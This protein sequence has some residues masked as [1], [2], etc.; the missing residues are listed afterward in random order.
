MTT[1]ITIKNY[2]FEIQEKTMREWLEKFGSCSFI[3]IIESNQFK[4]GVVSYSHTRD[5]KKLLKFN[6][7]KISLNSIEFVLQLEPQT[8]FIS[9]RIPVKQIR[10]NK[11][12]RK[13]AYLQ[14]EEDRDEI[15]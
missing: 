2:P 9:R 5:A 11:A 1:N 4:I 7:S 6:N 10:S 8:K 12:A 3:S 15:K 14:T 13:T